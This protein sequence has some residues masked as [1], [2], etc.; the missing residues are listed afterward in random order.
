L[1]P[2]EVAR[3]SP[4]LSEVDAPIPPDMDGDV[5]AVDAKAPI[6]LL[7]DQ[8]L[9]AHALDDPLQPQPADDARE[10]DQFRVGTQELTRRRACL[11][12]HRARPDSPQ[13]LGRTVVTAGNDL[14]QARCQRSHSSP[15][16]VQS[17]SLHE[18]RTAS[19][20]RRGNWQIT[21]RSPSARP[22]RW[23]AVRP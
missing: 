7:E 19:Q 16:R 2:K 10:T 22:R 9:R 6:L 21:A 23:R 8:M 5:G 12:A 4:V 15:R 3:Y 17:H 13:L 1:V 11:A 18:S 14:V 20:R